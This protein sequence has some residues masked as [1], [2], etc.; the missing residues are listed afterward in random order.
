MTSAAP[1]GTASEWQA[2][3]LRRR[4]ACF[5]YEGVLLFGVVMATGL[6]YGIVTQ[7]RHALQ[8]QRGLQA[9]VFVVLGLYFVWFWSHGGQTLAM[10]TWQIRVV[11]R[12]G[13]PPSP[14]RAALRYL[15]SWLWFLPALLWAGATGQHQ[16]GA[17]A[18]ALTVG[19]LGYAAL[20]LL[21]PQRQ[22]WHD[23]L[24]GTR[25]VRSRQPDK[26]R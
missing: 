12:D 1:P 9:V 21:N 11:G 6:V 19:V 22:Y 13:R 17:I 5:V 2:P 23:L 16:G 4:V 7:Q 15:G 3:S 26:P 20:T 25:L 18:A 24:A 10:K 8:G 14:V